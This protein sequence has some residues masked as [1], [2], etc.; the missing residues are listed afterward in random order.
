MPNELCRYHFKRS[1]SQS[2]CR[3]SVCTYL[4]PDTP[5][6]DSNKYWCSRDFEREGCPDPFCYLYH[7]KDIKPDFEQAK[8]RKF[9]DD[10]PSSSK[11]G[12]GGKMRDFFKKKRR[13][14]SKP[15]AADER[16]T[17]VVRKLKEPE[18]S[19][20]MTVLE[21][22]LKECKAKLQEYEGIE[23]ERDDLDEE[24]MN[25][26]DMFE[27]SNNGHLKERNFDCI[28][29]TFKKEKAKVV[30]LISQKKEIE[31]ERD[32]MDSEKMDFCKFIYNLL[33]VEEEKRHYD[34][35]DI[36]NHVEK[37]HKNLCSLQSL[38]NDTELKVKDL[39]Q[40]IKDKETRIQVHS[41]AMKT[42]ST[43]IESQSKDLDIL[44]EK[45][46]VISI[47]LDIQMK[48]KEEISKKLDDNK[49]HIENLEHLITVQRSKSEEKEQ[50]KKIQI[51]S[52]SEKMDAL[53]ERRKSNQ[54]KIL[55]LENN[56]DELVGQNLNLTKENESLR[57]ELG[58][59]DEKICH[60]KKSLHS[61]N[62]KL[63]NEKTEYEKNLIN[64]QCQNSN[65]EFVHEKLEEE[66]K[67]KIDTLTDDIIA[68]ELEKGQLQDQVN[69]LTKDK[70]EK[71]LS[72]LAR[73]QI[74][75]AKIEELKL[76]EQERD[77]IDEKLEEKHLELSKVSESHGCLD[78]IN[79][80]LKCDLTKLSALNEKQK[81]TFK[82]EIGQLEAFILSLKEEIQR[83]NTQN[84]LLVRK[85]LPVAQR[86]EQ[87]LPLITGENDNP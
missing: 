18:V 57:K 73:D 84:L 8:K 20:S 42:L 75:N 13:T 86:F 36:Q 11:T 78:E 51:A 32:W 82:M 4:H 48:E 9:E 14:E 54:A 33:R 26:L 28:I 10:R 65:H 72:I 46:N 7:Q 58:K 50:E 6:Y 21:T 85:I 44:R 23:Q 68:L 40:T 3:N 17:R 37:L 79:R 31:T 22:S 49:E 83:K 76:M 59:S 38:V 80:D 60:L 55:E 34:L 29:D 41:T 81:S 64:L 87:N 30:E 77:S 35:Q 67:V 71:H 1:S 12:V 61:V 45:N 66:S 74:I 63:E 19:D 70:D 52:L 25:F 5:V 24:K 43:Q 16:R 47:G 15:A 56:K 2:H 27:K 53:E 39:N 69:N 62:K